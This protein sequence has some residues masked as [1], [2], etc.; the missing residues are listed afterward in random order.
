PR[1]FM[2]NQLVYSESGAAVDTVL[3][4]GRVVVERGA[5]TTVDARAVYDQAR[6]IVARIYAGMDERRRRFAETAG[7]LGAVRSHGRGH[8]PF[9]PHLRPLR[10]TGPVLSAESGSSLRTQHSAL[11]ES[12]R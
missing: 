6:A 2:L 12:C 4:D 3:V 8:P 9:L 7:V 5:V 10:L 11:V 1:E